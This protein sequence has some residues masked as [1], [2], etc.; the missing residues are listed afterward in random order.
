MNINTV[1]KLSKYFFVIFLI[2]LGGCSSSKVI[3][4]EKLPMK[5][6][7]KNETTPVLK[8][9]EV[10]ERE[11]I[12]EQKIST[13]DRLS[14]VYDSQGKLI[15][16]GKISSAKYDLKGFLTET[17]TFD[18]KGKVMNR[19]QY[20]YDSKGLRTESLR[21][22]AQN[23]LDKK[24]A[25]EYDKQGNKIRSIRYDM[26]GNAEKYYVY[27]YDSNFN[28]ISDEWY[29]YSDDLEYKIETEYDNEGN[30]T[31][32]FSYNKNGALIYKYVFKYDDKKNIIEEQKYDNKDKPVGII[33]YLYKYYL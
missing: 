15:G 9:L 6:D 2:Y 3:R 1:Q 21:Y 10:R 25:Y 29:N 8:T 14:F 28:L 31:S 30:K 17:I 32:S 5:E 24:Y 20:K 7:K 18:E 13:V 19:Y 33:Q 26:K 4:Y 11:V 12:R 22:D 23:N 27:N 16:K